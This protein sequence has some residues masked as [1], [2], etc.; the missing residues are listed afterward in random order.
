LDGP[1]AGDTVSNWVTVGN[2]MNALADKGISVVA[3]APE[4]AMFHRAREHQ[5]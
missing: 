2:P 3:P 1:N 5:A 4:M